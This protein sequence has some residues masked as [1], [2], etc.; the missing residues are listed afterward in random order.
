MKAIICKSS[1][2]KPANKFA[3]DASSS[4]NT[5][6]KN[7]RNRNVLGNYNNSTNSSKH[8]T[9]T[10]DNKSNVNSI[11]D[12]ES[13]EQARNFLLNNYKPKQHHPSIINS[14][15]SSILTTIIE[16]SEITQ[17]QESVLKRKN[18]H[19]LKSIP[20]YNDL[21]LSSL[22]TNSLLEEEEIGLSSENSNNNVFDSND[23]N[24]WGYFDVID[25]TSSKVEYYDPNRYWGFVGGKVYNNK[26]QRIHR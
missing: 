13:Y 22:S 9:I 17:Q 20:T 12:E 4:A 14:M 6:T 2:Y 19:L 24:S 11:S 25:S 21:S 23:N 16:G 7:K 18:D 1:T 15:K 3:I 26:Y 8:K 5:F 10:N